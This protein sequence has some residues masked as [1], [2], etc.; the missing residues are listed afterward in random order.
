MK[1]DSVKLNNTLTAVFGVAS[2][3]LRLI[4]MVP[5]I[6]TISRRLRPVVCRRASLCN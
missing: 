4:F 3:F 1:K 6:I 5:S 2:T